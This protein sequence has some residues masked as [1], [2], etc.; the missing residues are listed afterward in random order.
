MN[1]FLHYP[2]EIE[3]FFEILS[4]RM[5]YRDQTQNLRQQREVGRSTGLDQAPMKGFKVHRC[6]GGRR[7][8][9]RRSG[10]DPILAVHGDLRPT[11]ALYVERLS[12]LKGYC[13]GCL[14]SVSTRTLK[15]ISMLSTLLNSKMSA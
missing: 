11:I 10:C 4:S 5:E 8:I 6:N 12:V 14:P 2:T 3:S 1:S 7:K 15:S 13:A 9:L